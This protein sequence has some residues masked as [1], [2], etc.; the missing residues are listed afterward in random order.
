AAQ[1]ITTTV[2]GV[3]DN[4]GVDL[5]NTGA[6]IDDLTLSIYT[7]VGDV[8]DVLL[9]SITEPIASFPFG[10]NTTTTIDFSGLGIF[11]SA[12]TK[13]VLTASVVTPLLTNSQYVWGTTVDSGYAGG[14]P[15]FNRGGVGDPWEPIAAHNDFVFGVNV[16]PV[17]VP[18]ALWLFGSGLLGLIGI[19]RH[20]KVS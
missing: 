12:N 5:W 2:G 20:K 16:N 18:P 7:A 8:P 13:Y 11:L 1:S 9:G 17:P 6:A 14:V 4:I 19:S 3:L 10:S 15:S